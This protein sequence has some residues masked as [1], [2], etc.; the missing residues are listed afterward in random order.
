MTGLEV[1]DRHTMI[2][3]PVEKE[4][5]VGSMMCTPRGVNQAFPGRVEGGNR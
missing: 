4:N 5:D 1:I 3:T 2:K